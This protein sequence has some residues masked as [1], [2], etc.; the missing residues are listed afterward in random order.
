MEI[1][2]NCCISFKT[3]AWFSSAGICATSFSWWLPHAGIGIWTGMRS[4][5]PTH[6]MRKCCVHIRSFH[7]KLTA[8]YII[9]HHGHKQSFENLKKV[10][11][12]RMVWVHIIITSGMTIGNITVNHVRTVIF[13]FFCFSVACCTCSWSE[14]AIYIHKMKTILQTIC[15]SI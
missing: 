2:S 12:W 14:A 4:M 7:L 10:L 1:Q 9:R 6:M 13:L 3:S 11:L 8:P 15:N 5:D